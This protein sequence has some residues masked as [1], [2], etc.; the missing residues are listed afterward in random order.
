MAI[1][2]NRLKAH[3]GVREPPTLVYGL[4]QQ[5]A[6]PDAWYLDDST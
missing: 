6:Q 5:L 1:A 3:L 4:I 2:Y